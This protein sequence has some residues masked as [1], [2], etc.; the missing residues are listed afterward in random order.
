MVLA[1][2]LSRRMTCKVEDLSGKARYKVQH[3][4]ARTVIF[5]I[6]PICLPACISVVPEQ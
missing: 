6:P 4:K 5:E 2:V 3:F 1:K